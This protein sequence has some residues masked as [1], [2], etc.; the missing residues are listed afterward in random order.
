MKSP[1]FAL[2]EKEVRGIFT[3][4]RIKR[5]WKDKVRAKMRNHLL[6]DPIEHLDFHLRLDA[7]CSQLAKLVCDGV[8]LPGPAHRILMEKSKGLCRQ[9]VIP[10]I[11]DALVLQCLSDALYQDIKGKAPSKRAFFEPEDHTFSVTRKSLIMEPKYGFF[12]AWLDFQKGLFNFTRNHDYVVITDIANYYDFISYT[13]LR[14]IIADRIEVRESVLDMLIF[15]LS[16]LLWQPDYAPRVEIGLPQMDIDAP[17]IL[18]HC[19]LYELDS[20]LESHGVD[21]VRFMDDIDIGVKSVGEARSFLRDIDL[22]LQTRQVRLNSGKT[23]I[24][25]RKDAERHFRVRENMLLNLVLA[26]LDSKTAVQ[27]PIDR[28]RRVIRGVLHRYYKKKKFDDGNGEK[29]LGRLLSLSKKSNA[30]VEN[31][32]LK[33][34]LRRR[35]GLRS[36]GFG[37]IEWQGLTPTSMKLVV[38]FLTSGV[39][40]DDFAFIDGA[41]ALVHAVARNMPYAEKEARRLAGFLS[42][43]GFFGIYAAIWLMS[44]YEQSNVLYRFL[45][46]QR[47]AWRDDLWLGRVVGGMAPIFSGTQEEEKFESLVQSSKNAG[48]EEVMEFHKL[49]ISDTKVV[50]GVRSI[51]MARNTFK[52]LQI[53]HAK[54]L[55]LLSVLGNHTLSEQQK[56]IYIRQHKDA[57]RDAFYRRRARAIVKPAKLK[58]MIV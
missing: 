10:N 44:K 8:Y 56:I 57:W 48:A 29:I 25:R 14:N 52:K 37:V 42:R 55:M 26:R 21:Y 32:L 24:L 46:D 30:R 45:E 23:I 20:F 34:I 11:A 16:G 36:T 38:D 53:T 28:E 58:A 5:A 54:F 41:N 49:L 4:S 19:F 7:R 12:R 33:D 18:A 50:A 3:T 9:I 15:I 17:R 35:P 22:I 1:R 40:V 39:V 43:K 51:V 47:E 27:R 6:P 2:R 13:H 31:W